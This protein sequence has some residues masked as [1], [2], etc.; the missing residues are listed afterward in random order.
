MNY[1]AKGVSTLSSITKK[2]VKTA[3]FGIAAIVMSASY[4]DNSHSKYPRFFPQRMSDTNIEQGVYECSVEGIDEKVRFD[5]RDEDSVFLWSDDR[6]GMEFLE[7]DSKK[8]TRL[9]RGTDDYRCDLPG[10]TET[11]DKNWMSVH[12]YDSF[13]PL[14][15]DKTVPEMLS[16]LEV[17]FTQ[18]FEYNLKRN[19][20]DG[21][22][23]LGDDQLYGS[24]ARE[25]H[26]MIQI[27]LTDDFIGRYE[28]RLPKLDRSLYL[29]PDRKTDL[30]VGWGGNVNLNEFFTRGI[31]GFTI[32]TKN[33]D[34]TLDGGFHGFA[35]AIRSGDPAFEGGFYMTDG[36]AL[37]MLKTFKT[38][39]GKTAGYSFMSLIEDKP[40]RPFEPELAQA[41]NG[42]NCGDFANYA[43]V[44]SGFLSIADTEAQKMHLWYPEEFWDNP[45]PRNLFDLMMSLDFFDNRQ[46][47]RHIRE[48]LPRYRAVRAWEHTGY[49]NWLATQVDFRSKR[50]IEDLL[51]L[52]SLG[53]RITTPFPQGPDRY[54]FRI[55]EEYQEYQEQGDRMMKDKLDHAGVGIGTM[56]EYRTLEDGLKREY[57]NQ[58]EDMGKGN[59]R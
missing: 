49:I 36:Q 33:E 54:R 46:L 38:Y 3:M 26:F 16:S 7:A 53:A 10:R 4:S 27:H 42:N 45:V 51:P 13:Y 29:F 2:A 48:T 22:G 55:T 11:D 6:I 20:L 44:N 50:V 24:Q 43:L 47:V 39:P 17:I 31:K 5:S 41:V 52:A 14:I 23:L 19:I 25:G 35:Q 30:F 58:L 56:D 59:D 40:N 8:K 12:I 1:L 15:L 34:G 28:G 57:N 37:K 21:L 18:N 9:M 32:P